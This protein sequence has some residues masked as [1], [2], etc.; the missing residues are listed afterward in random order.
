MIQNHTSISAEMS[1]YVR[2]A[3]RKFIFNSYRLFREFLATLNLSDVSIEKMLL[4]SENFRIVLNNFIQDLLLI[5]E[6][7]EN[8]TILETKIDTIL[9][10]TRLSHLIEIM[11]LNNQNEHF[12]YIIKWLQVNFID[13]I[14]YQP[15][16][17]IFC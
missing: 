14:T 3:S 15:I 7:V 2:E 4:S 9:E 12:L 8:N 13:Y 5:E 10:F 17:I 16:F 11:F 6:N 1:L